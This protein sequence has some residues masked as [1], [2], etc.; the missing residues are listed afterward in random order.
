VVT[1]ERFAQGMTAQQYVDQMSMNR[2]RFLAVLD[3]IAIGAGDVAVLERLAATRRI[4]VITEDW[5]GA[6][7]GSLPFVVKLVEK[8]PRIELR[9]FLR[10]ANP[11]LM[12]Q[13]LKNGV[14]RSIPVFVFFDE[15]M[16]ELARF[17]E[18]RPS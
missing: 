2:D 12:D 11:D 14:Y 9:I 3:S 18:Q 4:L 6:A 10:D 7:I 13:F 1:S 5:C 15:Q 8:T 17:I 16:N